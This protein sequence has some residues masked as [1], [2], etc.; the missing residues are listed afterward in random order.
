MVRRAPPTP[1]EV[2]NPSRWYHPDQK[3]NRCCLVLEGPI[4]GH[5][6]WEAG[7]GRNEADHMFT[8]T[9]TPD[10]IH[11]V[12]CQYQP[13]SCTFDGLSGSCAVNPGEDS[14]QSP[15]RDCW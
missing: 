8:G 3:R 9:S 13:E 14:A 2:P 4:L 1:N 7:G 15:D 10:T 11:P 6:C 12:P 5:Y